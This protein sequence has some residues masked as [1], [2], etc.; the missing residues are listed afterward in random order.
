MRRPRLF[1]PAVL[2]AVACAPQDRGSSATPPETPEVVAVAEG[3]ATPESVIWDA[4]QQVWLVTNINGG[5][6]QKDGNGFISRLS[7][8]GAVT[9]REWIQGGRDGVTLHAPKGTALQG[10]TLW[11]ADI[12]AVRGFDRV[13]GAPVATIEFGSQARF[14][15]DLTVGP[16]GALY[17]TD[18]G[19]LIGPAGVEH[20][21][22]D[23]IF[24]VTGRTIAVLAEGDHLERPNGIAWDAGNSRFLIVA[25]G[26]GSLFAMTPDGMLSPFGTG[27]GSQDGVVVLA[28]GRVLVSSWSDSTVFEVRADGN[29]ALI[30]G[31][32][33]PADI[34]V[35]PARSIV[36]IPLFNE[37]R[38]EFWRVP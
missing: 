1:L 11:V 26:G 35:D 13:T 20:P 14:L 24:R 33:A 38:V 15:N 16:D 5:P 10:D 28:D 4:G 32:D 19:I 27:P 29:S 3:F 9:E 21:G 6:S 2:F 22:P 23:R 37:N 7:A 17:V 34:G 12:D 36:A 30:A 8:D 31:I 25:F 18:T